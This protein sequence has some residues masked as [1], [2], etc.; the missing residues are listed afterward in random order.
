MREIESLTDL[1]AV[2]EE[3]PHLYS[4]NDLYHELEDGYRS[5][6]DSAT[7]AWYLGALAG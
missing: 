5:T 6:P 1:D 7:Y 4:P 3:E 2:L